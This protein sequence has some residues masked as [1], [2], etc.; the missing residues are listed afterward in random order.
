[1]RRGRSLVPQ[2]GLRHARRGGLCGN[3]GF[4]QF[5][6]RKW[7]WWHTYRATPA[8]GRAKRD[9]VGVVGFVLS[10]WLSVRHRSPSCVPARRFKTVVLPLSPP[11][12]PWAWADPLGP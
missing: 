11:W 9:A 3:R 1:M 6:E 10:V 5:L 4:R 2:R 8:W 12:Q 7:G